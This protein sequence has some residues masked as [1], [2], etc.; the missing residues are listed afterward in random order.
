MTSKVF[1]LLPALA[2]LSSCTIEKRVYR[3][4]YY[5]E[6]N[7]NKH[8]L[9]KQE[10]AGKAA[11]QNRII[12]DEQSETAPAADADPAAPTTENETTAAAVNNSAMLSSHKA[13]SFGGKDNQKEIKKELSFLHYPTVKTKGGDQEKKIPWQLPTGLVS[14]LSANACGVAAIRNLA[15]YSGS[16]SAF[17]LF[18][19]LTIIFSILTI[20][21]SAIALSQIYKNTDKFRGK[22]F[23]ITVLTLGVIITIGLAGPLLL[24]LLL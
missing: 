11:V 7:K 5:I 2:F 4:G 22:V 13:I 19:I 15:L 9:I 14:L 16:E 20:V 18:S 12:T 17:M 23:G 1:W 3:S 6:W 21:L 8:D 24:F 10:S